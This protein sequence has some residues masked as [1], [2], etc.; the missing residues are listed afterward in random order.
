MKKMGRNAQA[1]G[2]AVYLDQLDRLMDQPEEYDVD[3][4]IVYG[5]EVNWPDVI[6]A[7]KKAREEG[8]SVRVQREGETAIRSRQTLRM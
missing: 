3:L 6:A 1:M 2:F 4:L 8:R 5:G 7:A